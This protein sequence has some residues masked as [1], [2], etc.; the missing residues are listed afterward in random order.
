MKRP[1]AEEDEWR[2]R[3]FES[4]VLEKDVDTAKA[5]V[6]ANERRAQGMEATANPYR[7]LEDLV[8]TPPPVHATVDSLLR[9]IKRQ[10]I[11]MVHMANVQLL[12]SGK[13][14]PAVCAELGLKEVDSG[15][16]AAPAKQPFKV[17]VC[18]TAID[19]ALK[20]NIADRRLALQES[21]YDTEMSSTEMSSSG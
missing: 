8:D 2:M 9:T 13:T 7:Y 18:M 17:E 1:S 3:M 11:Q 10:K 15:S 5:T 16:G 21:G 4:G 12:Y 6:K 19:I 14:Y 20:R